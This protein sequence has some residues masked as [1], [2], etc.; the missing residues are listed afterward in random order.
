[1]IALGT[2]TLNIKFISEQLMPAILNAVRNITSLSLSLSLFC[3]TMMLQA[4]VQQAYVS[5]LT[6]YHYPKAEVQ[7]P[8]Q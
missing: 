4:W 7:P 6:V 8:L 3:T 2:P 5:L 1:L